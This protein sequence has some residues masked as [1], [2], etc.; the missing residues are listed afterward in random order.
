MGHR[1]PSLRC[2]TAGHRQLSQR[3]CASA[4]LL[5]GPPPAVVALRRPCA[6][7]H[8]QPFGCPAVTAVPFG[9][10]CACCAGV[11]C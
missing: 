9:S 2:Y 6:A 1:Q 11:P 5:R 7:A 3:W 4:P 10:S 8:C